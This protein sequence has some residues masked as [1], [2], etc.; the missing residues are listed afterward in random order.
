VTK[1]DI[2]LNFSKMCIIMKNLLKHFLLLFF[3]VTCLSSCH[4]NKSKSTTDIEGLWISTEGT[5]AKFPNGK[6][7]VVLKINR[8]INGELTAS[9]VFLWNGNYQSEWKLENE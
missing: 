8:S 3:V 1:A 6:Q 4:N 9:G 7:E 5:T 2:E